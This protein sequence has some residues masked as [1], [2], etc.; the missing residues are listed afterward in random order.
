MKFNKITSLL[1]AF[2]IIG[3]STLSVS[4]TTMAKTNKSNTNIQSKLYD[5]ET[6][7]LNPTIDLNG[8]ISWNPVVNVA[9]YT[10]TI[11]KEKTFNNGTF[12]TPVFNG[13]HDAPTT[14]ISFGADIYSNYGFGTYFAEVN[15]FDKNGSLLQRD[16]SVYY[17]DN[18]DYYGP[19]L[20]KIFPN[21]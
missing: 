15:A 11:S 14:S 5:S 18:S 17:Y 10:F 16:I 1:I 4:A 19:K 13:I 21:S 6:N 2:S 12:A 7:L 8:T 3:T 20:T 9:Y